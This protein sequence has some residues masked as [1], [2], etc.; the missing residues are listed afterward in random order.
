[1]Q[2]FIF[3]YGVRCEV[4]AESKELALKKMLALQQQELCLCQELDCSCIYEGQIAIWHES[5]I[6]SVTS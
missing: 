5:Q 3:V 6:E 1:M 2:T 4:Q